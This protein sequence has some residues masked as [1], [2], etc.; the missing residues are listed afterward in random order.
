MFGAKHT[1]LCGAT[2]TS[3]RRSILG[4]SSKHSSSSWRIGYSD[5]TWTKG[6]INITRKK[7]TIG[8]VSERSWNDAS[9]E[10]G[11]VGRGLT[12]EPRGQAARAT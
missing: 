6:A 3:T 7:G 9:E 12:P 1:T 8:D 10:S 2:Q 5:I 11:N 4:R